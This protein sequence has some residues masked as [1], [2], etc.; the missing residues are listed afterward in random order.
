MHGKPEVD[1]FLAHYASKYY[2]PA[3]AR[4]YYLRTREL[5]GDQPALSKESAQR[6]R[7]ANAYVS[8]E[9]KNKRD[10]ELKTNDQARTQLSAAAEKRQAAHVV[11]MEKLQEKATAEREK[12]VAKFKAKIEKIEKQ[13]AIPEGASPKLRA[14]LTKQRKAQLGTAS[15]NARGEMGKLA[16]EFRGAIANARN[17]YRSFR[18]EN[19]NARRNLSD[20]RRGINDTYRKELATEKQNIKDQV[21]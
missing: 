17:E 7:E 3:K 18:V 21:R 19:S 5:K 6:Q 8:N 12:I 16:N 9:L 10:A 2:D 11:R 13:L 15:E 4:E 1:D 14:F 20:Q